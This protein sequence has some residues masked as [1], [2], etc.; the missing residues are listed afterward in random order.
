MLQK[1]EISASLMGRLART[2]MSTLLFA[3]LSLGALT[4]VKSESRT[5]KNVQFSLRA[6][7]FAVCVPF[8]VA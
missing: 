2:C 8:C 4:I 7:M 6:K 3:Y 5:L 1:P